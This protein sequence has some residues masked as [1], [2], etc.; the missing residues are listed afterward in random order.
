MS[1]SANRAKFSLH[2]ESV[3][4]AESSLASHSARLTVQPHSLCLS[5]HPCCRRCHPTVPSR[6][7]TS[8]VNL[9]RPTLPTTTTTTTG[10]T[11]LARSENVQFQ[12]CTF[13]LRPF[14]NR[15]S[16]I[17]TIKKTKK[18]SISLSNHPISS[19]GSGLDHP[20]QTKVM[21]KI[22]H[23]QAQQSK[24]PHLGFGDE[25]ILLLLQF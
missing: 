8:T 7:F 19:A 22:S 20:L 5:L 21:T 24:K 2:F 9:L 18:H 23:S 1:I 11:N 10:S 4:K 16:F 14:S 17:S 13:P 3:Q 12:H 25:L 15:K 6:P